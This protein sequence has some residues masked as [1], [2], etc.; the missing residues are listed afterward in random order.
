MRKGCIIILEGADASG[1]STL[2]T[3]IG[4]KA[5]EQGRDFVYL[6]GS[7]W[8]GVVEQE[9]ERM[10][11]TAMHLVQKEAVVVLDHFWIAEQLYGVEYRGAAAYDPTRMDALMK[12]Y[13]ALI[14]L[15]VPTNLSAQVAR[16]AER[17]ARGKEHFDRAAGII[18][19]YAELAAGNADRKGDG[20]LDRI[21]RECRFFHRD[22]TLH[23]DMDHHSAEVWAGQLILQA[24]DFREIKLRPSR[25]AGR[26]E[27]T[28]A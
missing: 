15:C 1:K 18:A 25:A 2:A 13:G 5:V 9:H 4:A 3:A 23:Y 21:T 16:H 17:H 10:A 7:P 28:L 6:H 8:P 19:R 26:Q 22:D 11:D 24:T 27:D 14:V 12:G 20:Y